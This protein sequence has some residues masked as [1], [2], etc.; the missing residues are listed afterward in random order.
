MPTSSRRT[1]GKSAVRILPSRSDPGYPPY[2]TSSPL[3]TLLRGPRRRVVLILAEVSRHDDLWDKECCEVQFVALGNDP[4]LRSYCRVFR[5]VGVGEVGVGCDLFEPHAATSAAIVSAAAPRTP[6]VTLYPERA[7]VMR[8]SAAA[9]QR[10]ITIGTTAT[11]G[12][13]Y[14]PFP[15]DSAPGS[16]YYGMT[17]FRA[18]LSYTTV[19]LTVWP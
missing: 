7:A 19:F 8:P 1:K 2:S 15:R 13:L 12:Y 4:L 6:A 3:V 16:G 17:P 5:P 14:R 18:I 10:L 11:L 9:A